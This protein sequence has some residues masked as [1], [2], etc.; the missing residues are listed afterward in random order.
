MIIY[1]LVFSKE[2]NIFHLQPGFNDGVYKHFLICKG[3]D[4]QGRHKPQV[5]WGWCEKERGE[6][7]M[8]TLICRCSARKETIMV[9]DL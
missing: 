2:Q 6:G 7:N 9:M 8:T 3:E 4:R 1:V 5:A